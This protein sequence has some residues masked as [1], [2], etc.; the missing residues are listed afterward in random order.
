[1]LYLKKK[2][3]ALINTIIITS[4][5]MTVSCFMF[6]LIQN[7]IE[8]S[9]MCY[10]DDDVFS[11]NACEEDAL[12]SFMKILNKKLNNMPETSELHEGEDTGD[13]YEGKDPRSLFDESFEEKS[14]NSTLIYDKSRDNLILK[15]IGD[16]NSVRIRQLKY[17]IKNNKIL[18]IP[19]SYFYDTNSKNGDVEQ[20]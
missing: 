14:Y 18:L 8:L 16:A 6:K 7:N 11:V 1:M 17:I 9:A 20:V 19:T 15:I 5:I 3:S 13:I 12:R 4:L 2:G 10:M